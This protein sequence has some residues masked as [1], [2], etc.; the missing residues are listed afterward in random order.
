MQISRLAHSED[1]KKHPET[2]IFACFEALYI[3]PAANPPRERLVELI[4]LCGGHVSRRASEAVL[5]VGGNKKAKRTAKP[6]V[7]ERWILGM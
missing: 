3:P 7:A 2:N 4:Q 5:W 6:V 1:A